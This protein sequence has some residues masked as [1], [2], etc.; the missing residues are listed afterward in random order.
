[1]TIVRAARPE[2]GPAFLELVRALAVFE[3]L[4]GPTD[5]AATRLLADAFG[6][7]ARYHLAVGEVDGQVSAYAVTF[8]TYSTFLA[9]PTLFLEDLFVHPRARRHGLGRAL[10]E[11]TI[12]R[13]KALDCGR[14]EWM[15]LDWNEPAHRFYEALGAQK[16]DSWQLYR[17][18]L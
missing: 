12:E 11:Q 3:K 2:D 7:S 1:M 5:E 9:K 18:A 16:L 4:P 6:P 14:V 15:V 8:Q 13:A 10:I 17:V